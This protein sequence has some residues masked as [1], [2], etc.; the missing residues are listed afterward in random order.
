MT[1]QLVLANYGSSLEKMRFCPI[2][3]FGGRF[4]MES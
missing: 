1:P 3:R 2:E 4:L